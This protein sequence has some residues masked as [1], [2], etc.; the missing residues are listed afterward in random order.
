[1]YTLV[2]Q[3][4]VFFSSVCRKKYRSVNNYVVFL[5]TTLSAILMTLTY[6]IYQLAMLYA[7]PFVFISG[8]TMCW[9]VSTLDGV[10]YPMMIV[11]LIIPL[12]N[13]FVAF[14]HPAFYKDELSLKRVILFLLRHFLPFLP[15]HQSAPLCLDHPRWNVLR[16]RYTCPRQSLPAPTRSSEQ[17]PPIP[18]SRWSLR[19]RSTRRPHCVVFDCQRPYDHSLKKFQS[20]EGIQRNPERVKRNQRAILVELLF[21]TIGLIVFSSSI[22]T[23]NFISFQKAE[24]EEST[25]IKRDNAQIGQGCSTAA[26]Y[27]SILHFF[28]AALEFGVLNFALKP[29]K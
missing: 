3:L 28:Y 24:E 17:S 1:M 27:L 10:G 21:K 5:T 29:R 11:S 19:L 9:I 8:Q 7:I 4:A 16:R 22:A 20:D 25:V 14:Q 6:I 23:L 12:L 15:N 13:R 2:F 18:A 26:D